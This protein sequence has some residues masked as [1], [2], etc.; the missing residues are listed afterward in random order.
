MSKKVCLLTDS[1]GSGG[2]EKMVANLSK[3]LTSKGYDITIVSMI[4]RIVYDFEGT[5]YNFGKIKNS[6]SRFKAFKTLQKFFK[7]QDFDVILDHRIR[8]KWIKEFLFLKFVFNKNRFIYCVHHYD[9]SMYFPLVSFPFLSK[10]TLVKQR[11][12]IAVSQ[13]VKKEIVK[14]LS[15]DSKVIYNYPVIDNRNEEPEFGFE[16]IIAIGRLEKIKQFDI[17]INCYKAS[18]LLDNGI[19]LLIF[20]EGSERN[21]LQ[22]LI[23]KL[24][25]ESHVFLKGF[26]TEINT[27]IKNAK[28]LVMTSKSE[29]FPMVLIEAIQ[30]KTPVVSFDCKSGPNEIIQDNVNGMLVKNQDK[31]EMIKALNMMVD[32]S[33]YSKLKGNLLNF[34]S[35]FVEEKIIKQWINLIE[36]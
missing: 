13:I 16:Y 32:E 28:V 6:L 4:D 14:R 15:L 29:G 26:S 11:E 10:L 27:Y 1:L 2:A 25:L 19:K 7:H 36:S 34:K 35:P 33:A 9:L 30:H 8:D 3:S 21:S 20:G 5:L 23:F 12:I 22:N 24:N 18:K 17:L 31:Y